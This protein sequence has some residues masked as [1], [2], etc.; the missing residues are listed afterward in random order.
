MSVLDL[1]LRLAEPPAVHQ[2]VW[3]QDLLDELVETWAAGRRQGRR[4]PAPGAA[5]AAV[6]GIRTTFPDGYVPR[7]A[8]ADLIADMPGTD[9][10]DRPHIA[11][12]LAGGASHIVTRDHE[13]FPPTI[14]RQ[15]FAIEVVDPDDYLALLAS[16]F[17]IECRAVVEA[18]VTHRQATREADLTVEALL[19]RWRTHVGL[20]TFADLLSA[21]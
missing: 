2:V 16:E 4:V 11:A 14:I 19:D 18:M 13:G 3:S 12:A 20:P 8:Y 1:F 21:Q 15:R 10:A 7:A 9:P 17:A 5:T 6:D